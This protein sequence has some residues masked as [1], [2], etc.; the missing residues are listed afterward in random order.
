MHML[1]S[2]CA[3]TGVPM[4]IVLSL[5]AGVVL[6][7][8]PAAAQEHRLTD[9]DLPR[10]LPILRAQLQEVRQAAGTIQQTDA[11]FDDGEA[12]AA[13]IRGGADAEEWLRRLVPSLLPPPGSVY[14]AACS[15]Q[16]GQ[17]QVVY[18]LGRGVQLAGWTPEVQAHYERYR[19]EQYPRGDVS[20]ESDA[21]LRMMALRAAYLPAVTTG[22]DMEL[23]RRAEQFYEGRAYQSSP[24]RHWISPDRLLE[25]GIYDQLHLALDCPALGNQPVVIIRY[26]PEAGAAGTIAAPTHGSAAAMARSGWSGGQWTSAFG[27]LMVARADV[28]EPSLLEVAAL[29]TPSELPL[30]RANAEWYRRHSRELEPL[31]A[32]LM[33]LMR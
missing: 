22:R 9:A 27:A 17:L 3:A 31:M 29:A 13:A 20:P 18:T 8:G 16:L 6:A 25:V 33:R 10:I 4:R 15:R 1:R 19:R 11:L 32:E 7:A 24:P 30:R 28:A 26:A 14:D 12:A 21:N 5:L 2:W 23:M